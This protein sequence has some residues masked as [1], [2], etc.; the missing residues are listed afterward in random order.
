MDR[1]KDLA[2]KRQAKDE[3]FSMS[4]ETFVGLNWKQ[5]MGIV[6]VK[7]RNAAKLKKLLHYSVWTNF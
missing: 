2:S 7:D 6:L 4:S 1:Y 5:I 3:D